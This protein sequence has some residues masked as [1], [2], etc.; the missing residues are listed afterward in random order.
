MCSAQETVTKN[1]GIRRLFDF[2]ER[3]FWLRRLDTLEL[4]F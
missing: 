2:R 4:T 1:L 3:P